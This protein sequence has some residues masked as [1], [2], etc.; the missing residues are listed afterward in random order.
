MCVYSRPAARG[1]F[2]GFWTLRFLLPP[3]AAILPQPRGPPA[4]MDG[5]RISKPT[6]SSPPGPETGE[7]S[8]LRLAHAH[9]HKPSRTTRGALTPLEEPSKIIQPSYLSPRSRICH[10]F[11][12]LRLHLGSLMG[13]WDR[14]CHRGT[15]S[16][17]FSARRR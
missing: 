1:C 14:H 17:A 12:P 7:P 8:L 2:K 15:S 13:L 4:L 9:C 3:F 16:C 11:S 6:L 5:Q 10:E